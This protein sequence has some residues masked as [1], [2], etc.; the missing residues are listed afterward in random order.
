MTRCP[1]LW[2]VL[3]ALALGSGCG[4]E[5]DESAP[6]AVVD[7][8][9]APDVPGASDLPDVPPAVACELAAGA[10]APDYLQRL[11]CPDDFAAL[12]SDPLD[13]S[14]PGARSTKTVIDRLDGDSC[15]FQNSTRYAIHW[16]FASEHLSGAGLPLVPP[17]EQFNLTEYYS[18]S[19]RFLLAAITYYEEPDV[20]AYE[21]APYDGSTAEMIAAGYRRLVETTWLGSRL[22][23]HPTSA[24]LEALLPELPEDVAVVTTDQLFEDVTYQPL[25][26]GSAVGRLRFFSAASLDADPA[27]LDFRDI[28]VL[29]AVPNDIGVA[30]A[31]ITAAFQTPLS[32]INVL[33]Q[34]RGTPNMALVGALDDARLEALEGKWVE[35][36][37]EPF[38]WR[39]REVSQ[40]DADAWWEANK[41]SAIGVPA[42]DVSVTE[43]TDIEDVLDLD[44][45]TLGEAIDAAIPAFGGKASHYG[46]FPHMGA[47]F[48]YPKAFCVP[49]AHYRQFMADNGFDVWVDDILAD[50]AVAAD[51]RVRDT[52]LQELQDAIKVAPVAASFSE[53]LLAKLT[54]EYPGV[55]MRFRSSTNAEDLDGFTGAG[56]YTSKSGDPSDP[57]RPVLDA[58]RKVWASTWNTR[59]FQEREYRSIDH[60]AV[61]MALLVHRSFPDEE[62]NGVALTGNIFDISGLEPGFYVNVQ[63]GE[64]S[65]VKPPAGVTSDQF[66][67][68]FYNP[69]Q[70][71]VYLSHSSLLQP[72]HTVLTSAQT[73]A[74]GQA[75][76]EIHKA[77]APL[78]GPG[79][80]EAARF[81]AMD[82]EFKL[83]GEP[84]EEPTLWIKQ[85]RPHP[86]WGEP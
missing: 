80:G 13:A 56:L 43:L 38:E 2:V 10:P 84:G 42:L 39:V 59:A 71:I 60:R 26:L 15:Y 5:G 30:A 9:V 12:A 28:A 44:T 35:L 82:V 1:A 25:N 66:V 69:G 41:P 22:R 61:G 3:C 65:V 14:I 70:P 79:P 11:G 23:F 4:S 78:Y 32:H 16:E 52:R 19:R 6:D 40:A 49:I 81:Y 24:G 51:P 72:G 48:T 55:R 31:I 18:P 73:H 20:W 7:A 50:P 8:V 54:G 57:D 17:L 29:D 67:Y 53:A 34:N 37:V 74:L 86:G 33:S 27:L 63:T 45:Q 85:A 83:D 21:L 46:Y 64:T 77:F 36:T 76:D 47:T 68:Y 58:V 62:A 75:L